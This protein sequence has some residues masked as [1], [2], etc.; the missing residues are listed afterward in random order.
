MNTEILQNKNSNTAFLAVYHGF[1]AFGVTYIGF[2][3]EEDDLQEIFCYEYEE[4]T[5]WQSQN[6]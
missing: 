4:K 2:S 1:S 6:G 3:G 5:T